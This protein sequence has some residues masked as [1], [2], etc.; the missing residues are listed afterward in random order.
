MKKRTF[1][2]SGFLYYTVL[3]LFCFVCITNYITIGYLSRYSDYDEGV[4]SV[5]LASFIINTVPDYSKNLSIDTTQGENSIDYTFSVSNN[6]NGVITEVATNYDIVIQSSEGIPNGVSMEI[7][8]ITPTKNGNKY[9]FSDVG[10]FSSGIAG[11]NTHVITFT[12]DTNVITENV[13]VNNINI[14]VIAKQVK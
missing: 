6:K 3:T 1:N 7:N 8:G 5:Q 4:A 2:S 10:S 11:T 14:N 13:N 12:A 9:I